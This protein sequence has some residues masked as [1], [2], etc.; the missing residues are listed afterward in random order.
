MDA[1]RD[2]LR[3]I[4]RFRGK[5]CVL[6][7]D[8]KGST[9]IFSEEGDMAAVIIQRQKDLL[10]EEIDKVGGK[11]WAVGGDGILAFFEASRDALKA[12]VEIQKRIKEEKFSV[13]A[14]LHTGDV[15]LDP[16]MQSQTINIASRI[17]SLADGGQILTSSAT[18]QEAREIDFARFHSHGEYSLKGILEPIE[19]YEV[20]WHK[21]QQPKPPP[22]KEE[23]QETPS[24]LVVISAP[25]TA[26]DGVSPPGIRL[27]IWREWQ[28]ILETVRIGENQYRP[29][30][31]VRLFPPTRK[32]LEKTLMNQEYD[33]FHFIG[34]GA[35]D[36]LV[37]E[38]KYGREDLV[39]IDKLEDIFGQ[40]RINTC[41]SLAISLVTA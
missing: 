21:D 9:A 22:S 40:G 36:G 25:A 12:V 27:D 7:T 2:A 8:M 33:I 29:V 11:A 13:R 3:Q 41:K 38:D 18:Y 24:M 34:H 32:R 4:G 31:I 17:M 10:M 35:S 20:L 28:N 23:P 30:N 14:G 6:I 5:R 1:L 16:N 39:K 15:F 37:F 19:V 26:R